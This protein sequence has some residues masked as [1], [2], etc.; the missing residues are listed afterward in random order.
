MLPTK[1]HL[2]ASGASSA[3]IA[4]LWATHG[5]AREDAMNATLA[6]VAGLGDE[7]ETT[8]VSDGQ[9]LLDGIDRWR[10]DHRVSEIGLVKPLFMTL[11]LCVMTAGSAF[12]VLASALMWYLLSDILS[13]FGFAV[14]WTP[15]MAIVLFITAASVGISCGTYRFW[16]S[17]RKGGEYDLAALRRNRKRGFGEWLLTKVR[18]HAR[19]V[20]VV[21]RKATYLGSDDGERCTV[22]VLH[23]SAVA[24]SR[25]REVNWVHWVEMH[26]F[27]GKLV[28]FIKDV[29]HVEDGGH[30]DPSV[31]GTIPGRTGP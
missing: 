5:T 1:D 14:F 30:F 25:M 29:V 27:D 10:K 24:R 8:L 2:A 22:Q 3:G 17:V 19:H 20:V 16:E 31:F 9:S 15:M 7:V 18:H 26:G 21:G 23:H 13:D 12:V 6:E 28:A 4:E 11:F